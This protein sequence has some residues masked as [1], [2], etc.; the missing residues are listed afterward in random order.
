M[1]RDIGGDISGGYVS[2]LRKGQRDN[3][4]LQ[5]ICDLALALGVS[6]VVFVGGRAEPFVGDRQQLRRSFSGKLRHLFAHVYP[7]DRAPY[8][9]EEIAR[10]ISDDDRYDSI[11]GSYIRELL[12]PPAGGLPNP[13][14]K[15]VLG[16]ADHLGL[17]DT[18][19]PRA[20][21]FLDDAE[22]AAIN[23]ELAD[24]VA[25]RDAGVVSLVMRV[26]QHAPEWTPEMRNAAVA[27]ITD[28]MHSKAPTWV[29]PVS[30]EGQ[31][32]DIGNP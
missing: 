28:A 5:T 11:S 24:F 26:A 17:A 16:L 23:A 12:H 18:S 4:T 29:F 8:T 25:L 27:A 22:A 1:V 13:R 31:S 19:G 14:W 3:P 7:P 15:H 6:P 10:A 2:H 20:A 21:Y 9:P 32:R 30:S